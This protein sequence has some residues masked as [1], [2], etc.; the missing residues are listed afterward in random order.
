MHVEAES[1]YLSIFLIKKSTYLYIVSLT[2]EGLLYE[3]LTR[4]TTH[5]TRSLGVIKDWPVV[6]CE[7]TVSVAICIHYI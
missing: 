2:V 6:S 7:S 3:T 1:I 5:P 4:D